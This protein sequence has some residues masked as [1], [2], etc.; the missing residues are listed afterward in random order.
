[1]AMP[2]TQKIQDAAVCF[3]SG[4]DRAPPR[5]CA[6][7]NTRG[8]VDGFFLSSTLNREVG[9]GR[10]GG[11]HIVDGYGRFI[12]VALFACSL[13]CQEFLT[14]SRQFL[15]CPPSQP[16]HSDYQSIN[17]ARAPRHGGAV[18][19]RGKAVLD[20][21]FLESYEPYDIPAWPWPVH[22]QGIPTCTQYCRVRLYD[23]STCKESCA[24]Y[25]FL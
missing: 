4:D 25:R 14:V 18:D 15:T 5:N 13:Q 11:A 6:R 16:P 24:V 7:R 12:P 8:I 22:G 19:R 20:G 2:L 10:C 17:S 9:I 23:L 1:M 21:A 3:S